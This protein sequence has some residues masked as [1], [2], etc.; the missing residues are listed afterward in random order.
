MT[1]AG[2]LRGA[3]AAIAMTAIVD[4]ACT[5]QIEVPLPILVRSG[6]SEASDRALA[7]RV[8][9]RIASAL[10][11]RVDVDSPDAPRAIV[12][13]G[14]AVDV[15]TLP[16]E[17]PVSFVAVADRLNRNVSIA[18]VSSPPV[19]LA[20][21][22]GTIVATV[23][24]TRAAGGSSVITLEHKGIEL[25]RVEHQWTADSETFEARF[26]H[27]PP[28]AG[29]REM[30]IVARPLAGEASVGDNHADLR[31]M[32]EDRKLKVL[33]HEPRPSWAATFVRRVLEEEPLFEVAGLSRPSRGVEIRAGTAPA[34]LRSESL[35]PFDIVVVGAPEEL[36]EV[37]IDALER[38][39]RVRGGTFVLV[40]DRRPTGAYLKLIPAASFGERLLESPAAIAGT[41]V[42]L[43]ATELAIPIRPGP[44][45]DVI[46]SL[47]LTR[48]DEPVVIAWPMSA[49]RGMY[50]GA[51]DAW[52]HRAR[53]EEFAAFWRAQITS[54]AAVSPR[55]V[56]ATLNPGMASPGQL[57]TLQVRVRATE[58]TSRQQSI[59]FP[60]VG[61]SLTHPDGSRE[62]IRLWPEPEAGVFAGR[63][64]APREGHYTVQASAGAGVTFDTAL[65]VSSTARAAGRDA[66]HSLDLLSQATGGVAVTAGD[67]SRL[68]DHLASLPLPSADRSI[69]PGR[70][71]WWMAAFVLLLCAE[72][73]LRRRGGLS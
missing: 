46:A 35:D 73:G 63:F 23:V 9:Q 45:V 58:L 30:R 36:R 6:S 25:G 37:E 2:I 1:S 57:V 69:H 13:S 19:M 68:E 62:S 12:V 72:W 31:L 61:A 54:A 28:A 40:P 59:D 43:R 56:E 44:A 38:F 47:K 50:S 7:D 32:V 15:E 14:S 24:A 27:V 21:W 41:D 67:L 52:R 8:R 66:P 48:D 55:R 20:G 53:D 16:A 29:V 64:Q 18:G 33:V 39:A 11:E 42:S 22:T 26:A 3:A 51:L 49:G 65:I 4:P 71:T 17:V 60:I 70:S 10:Q 34:R 5:R